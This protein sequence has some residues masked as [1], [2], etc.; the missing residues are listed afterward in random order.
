MKAGKFK[1]AGAKEPAKADAGVPGAGAQLSAAAA[2]NAKKRA[3]K[4]RAA[5]AAA[6]LEKL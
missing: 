5:S 3:A 1:A 6:A 4:K 2:K